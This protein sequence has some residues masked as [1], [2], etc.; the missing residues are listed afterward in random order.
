MEVTEGEL[1]KCIELS[2]DL[3]D[4]IDETKCVPIHENH[5]AVEPVC[6]DDNITALEFVGI[7]PVKVPEIRPEEKNGDIAQRTIHKSTDQTIVDDG[8]KAFNQ[9]DDISD[10]NTHVSGM[11]KSIFLGLRNR[12]VN[13]SS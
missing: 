5:A 2:F 1:E 13:I 3:V 7:D 4:A 9:S 10:V 12:L 11:F 8:Y 6:M